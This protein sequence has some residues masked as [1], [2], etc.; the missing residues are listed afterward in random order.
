MA[1]INETFLKPHQILHHTN[2]A[3]HRLDRAEGRGGVVAITIKR[4][5][6]HKLLSELIENKIYNKKNDSFI[7]SCVYL[8]G[9]T[10]HILIKIHFQ[11]DI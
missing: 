10:S 11:N 6:S 5:I 3:I 2:Y 4:N 7:V 8:P 9:D 1:C